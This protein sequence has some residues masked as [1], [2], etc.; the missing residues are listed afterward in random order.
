MR[1]L[2]LTSWR[3][4]WSTIIVNFIYATAIACLIKFC[5]YEINCVWLT[6]RISYLPLL[7]KPKA[8]LRGELC[9]WTS[10]LVLLHHTTW[11]KVK[12]VNYIYPMG[13]SLVARVTISVQK[14]ARFIVVTFV[15]KR[16]KLS[17]GN[18]SK[19]KNCLNMH[20]YFKIKK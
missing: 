1:A 19:Q 11:T 10:C 13:E 3:T 2:I 14:L 12:L 5:N 9:K 18:G 4:V 16:N 17:V 6:W 7:E 8:L 15:P 20:V